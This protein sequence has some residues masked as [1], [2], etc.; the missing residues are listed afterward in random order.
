MIEYTAK[1]LFNGHVSIR[2][3]IVK[4]ALRKRESIRV[5]YEG[6]KMIIDR[7]QLKRAVD[8]AFRFHAKEFKSAFNGKK[9]MLYDFVWVKDANPVFNEKQLELF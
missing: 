3:Y 8:S 7:K 4:K 6:D 9:Y 5:S 1:K 2:D